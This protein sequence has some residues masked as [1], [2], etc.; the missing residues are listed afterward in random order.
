M[1][2]DVQDMLIARVVSLCE[3][4]PLERRTESLENLMQELE[5][6][7]TER[8]E[9]IPTEQDFGIPD[10]ISSLLDSLPQEVYSIF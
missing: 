6:I 10:L 5:E 9:E 4:I 3:S 1:S 2:N 8:P 7:N